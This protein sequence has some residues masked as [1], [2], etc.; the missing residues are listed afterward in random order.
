[1]HLPELPRYGHGARFYDL[2]SGERPVYRAGRVRAIELLRLAPGDRVLDIGCGTG[3]N[4]P[5]LRDKVG[6]TGHI[7]GIDASAA[8]LDVAA[9]KTREW[10]NVTLHEGDAGRLAT[11]VGPGEYDAMLVTYALSIIPDWR[12]TWAQAGDLLRPGGRI[13]VVDLALP[14]GLGRVF[15]PAAR[16]ACLTGGVELDRKPWTLVEDQLDDVTTERLRAGHVVVSVGTA[17]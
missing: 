1:M 11:I 6:P 17:P 12:S 2:L 7:T 16:L 10:G 3:L 13:G 4:I 8:M 14:T 5:L 9:R 15:E